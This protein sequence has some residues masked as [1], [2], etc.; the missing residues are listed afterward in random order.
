MY[1]SAEKSP[2][3][4][5]HRPG[6]EAT[7]LE[8]FNPAQLPRRLENQ[9]GNSALNGVKIGVFLE[10]L[11]HRPPIKPAVALRARGPDC[12]ALAPVEHAEL[13]GR[14]IGCPPH[15]A[16]EGI[17]LPNDRPLGD[18][19]DGWIAGHL[20]NRLERARDD[21][22][23][24]AAARSRNGGLRAGVACSDN[25]N[26]ELLLDGGHTREKLTWEGAYVRFPPRF[27]FPMPIRIEQDQ[28][29]L[30]IRKSAFERAG[31]ARAMFDERLGLADGEFQMEGELICVGPIPGGEDLQQIIQ[32]M[33]NAGLTY[34]EDFF[35]LSGN[36]PEWLSVFAMSR[37]T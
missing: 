33:E 12:G 17:D 13:Q 26:V 9:S 35:E 23:A 15:D 18:S 8:R 24:C 21:P 29:S 27:R 7:T 20:A 2:G 6:A 28:P 25:Q 19:A 11:P 10:E 34:F 36:W 37:G 1:T 16:T 32:E 5:H 22:N 3:G 31:L 4:D 30:L 14:H